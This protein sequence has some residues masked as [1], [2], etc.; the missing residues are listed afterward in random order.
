[1]VRHTYLN[2]ITIWGIEN[3]VFSFSLF[4]GDRFDPYFEEH[5]GT[6]FLSPQHSLYVIIGS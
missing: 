4:I 3:V 5:I 6:L 2:Q 1:M